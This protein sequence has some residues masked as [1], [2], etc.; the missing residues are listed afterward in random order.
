MG[1][2]ARE[3]RTRGGWPNQVNRYRTLPLEKGGGVM[4]MPPMRR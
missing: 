1:E 3:A 2:R 4:L